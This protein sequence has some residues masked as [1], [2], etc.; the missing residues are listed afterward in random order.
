MFEFWPKWSILGLSCCFLKNFLTFLIGKPLAFLSFFTPLYTFELFCEYKFLRLD[1]SLS[2]R[3]PNFSNYFWWRFKIPSSDEKTSPLL[4][5]LCVWEVGLVCWVCFVAV[6]L[7]LR[8]CLSSVICLAY[9]LNNKWVPMF[10]LAKTVEYI[11]LTLES[12]N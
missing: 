9:Q 11:I 4:S 5:P 1:T 7:S 10:N 8:C 6:T 3:F 12:S 2:E